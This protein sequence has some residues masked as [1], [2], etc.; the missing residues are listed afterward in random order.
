MT[1]C[2]PS[3]PLPRYFP[4][5]LAAPPLGPGEPGRVEASRAGE[6]RWCTEYAPPRL[7]WHNPAFLIKTGRE[8]NNSSRHAHRP[9]RRDR[10][11]STR[12]AA[13]WLTVRSPLP[14]DPGAPPGPG[15]AALLLSTRAAAAAA[16]SPLLRL[17][18]AR[19]PAS[20]PSQSHPPPLTSGLRVPARRLGC[21]PKTPRN[22]SSCL[23][24]RLPPSRRAASPRSAPAPLCTRR[25]PHCGCALSETRAAPPATLRLRAGL[26]PPAPPH[27]PPV[28][29]VSP[30]GLPAPLH[31]HPGSPASLHLHPGPPAPLHP[32]PGPP[33]PLHPHTVPLH[34]HPALL[35]RRGAGA[36]GRPR[37]VDGVAGQPRRCAECQRRGQRQHTGIFLPPIESLARRLAGVRELLV[38]E[39]RL[40]SG[41]RLEIQH[42]WED[43]PG[44]NPSGVRHV[45]RLEG[46]VRSSEKECWPQQVQYMG[47]DQIPVPG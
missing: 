1:H 3:S 18:L 29:P 47:S 2:T 4:P 40:P 7:V 34:P 19:A 42:P 8:I 37:W 39:G 35:P 14:T 45:W 43:L 9:V 28:P 46:L 13:P 20:S 27:G 17:P 38:R 6:M 5:H 30:H 12:G 22:F 44:A 31:L 26:L 21:A 41:L 36:S 24:P 11:L 23:R 32:H 33:A 16:A 15:R 25:R 10:R